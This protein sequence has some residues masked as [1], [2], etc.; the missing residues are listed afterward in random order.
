MQSNRIHDDYD[1]KIRLWA[2]NPQ[3]A[4]APLPHAWPRFPPQRFKSYGEMQEFKNRL[5]EL[6][7]QGA[8]EWTPS[9]KS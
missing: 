8:L 6:S 9:S 5:I 3:V 2:K 1:A 4:P 7:A